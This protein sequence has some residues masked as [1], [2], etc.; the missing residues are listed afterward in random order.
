MGYFGLSLNTS[1]LYG[2]PYVNCF[3][4]AAIE[5]PA[6]LISWLSVHFLPR[7]LSCVVSMTLAGAALYSVQIAPAGKR[8]PDH[9]A[10]LCHTCCLKQVFYLKFCD[11][12]GK[13]CHAMQKNMRPLGLLA[14]CSTG[15]IEHKE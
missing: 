1:R 8:Q 9:W 11:C 3:I 6:Y 4:S 13:T 14:P 7:R 15:S 10:M 12:V 5:V 2:D